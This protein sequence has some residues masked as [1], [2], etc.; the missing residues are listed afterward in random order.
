MESAGSRRKISRAGRAD[1][2]GV[3]R[4]IYSDSESLLSVANRRSAAGSSQVVE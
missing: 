3:L 4:G 2:I 1:D